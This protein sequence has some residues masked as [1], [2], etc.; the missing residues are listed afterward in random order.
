[1]ALFMV[2]V[3]VTGCSYLPFI[4]SE[5]P[6]NKVVRNLWSSGEQFVQIERQDRQ[7]GI[8]VRPNDHISEISVDRLHAALASI[9]ILPN[10]KGNVVPLFNEDELKTLG[11][12]IPVGLALSGPDDDVTFAVIG[13]YVEALGFLKK[14]EVTTGRVFYQ[15]G[16][17][18][19]I[20]GD[21]HRELKETM[22]VPEDRRLNPFQ[23]GSR[24]RSVGKLEGVLVP[25]EGGEI[26]AGIRN[27]WIAFPLKA[28]ETTGAAMAPQETT[29]TAPAPQE[30]G[31]AAPASMPN[32]GTLSPGAQTGASGAQQNTATPNRGAQPAAQAAMK[33]AVPSG[34][35]AQ[36]VT[37][38]ATH[39]RTAPSAKKS[40]EERLLILN[41]LRSKKLISEEEYWR[42]RGDILNDL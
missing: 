21:I 6:E 13:H 29:V 19:I 11:E 33:R 1:M 28:P 16:Q 39:E 30:T 32:P 18:N 25:K 27:D 7:T 20:F 17:I 24:A 40:T 4:H 37:P 26:F 12:Y 36:A 2:A 42:K 23:P 14:R 38:I 35:G 22:G 3:G 5:K 8:P 41:D 15:D 9:A 34:T 10:G 31:E